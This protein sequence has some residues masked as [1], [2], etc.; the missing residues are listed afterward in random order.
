MIGQRIGKTPLVTVFLLA[1]PQGLEPR[2][3]VPKT[4][5]LPLDD[6]PMPSMSLT[7][8]RRSCQARLYYETAKNRLE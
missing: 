4:V 5:V 8:G 7:G 3:T 1:G 6:G 2:P